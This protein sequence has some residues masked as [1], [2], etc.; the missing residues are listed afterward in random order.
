MPEMTR[1]RSTRKLGGKCWATDGQSIGL[2]AATTA[3]DRLQALSG[4]RTM[5]TKA[6][7]ASF[8]VGLH[9]CIG[10]HLVRRDMRIALEE[11]FE[12]VPEFRIAAD[13]RT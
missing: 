2:E 13:A 12:F 7:A 11:C 9:L 4:V 3:L 6:D 1:Q 5:T 10:M 8:D